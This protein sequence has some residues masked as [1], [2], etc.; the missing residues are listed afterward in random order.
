M[1]GFTLSIFTFSIKAKTPLYLPLYKGSTIRG[2]FGHALRRVCCVARKRDCVDCILRE[3]CIYSLVFETPVPEDAKMMR[4]YPSAPHPFVIDPPLDGQRLYEPGKIL[5]FRLILIGRAVDYLPYFVYSFHKLGKIGIGRDKGKF[6]LQK[7]TSNSLQG[8]GEV[9]VY[10]EEDK[11]LKSPCAPFA[12]SKIVEQ[13]PPESIRISFLTPTRIKYR[14]RLTKDVEFHVFFRN[15]L[16]RIS[17]LSYFHCGQTLN[18]HGFKELID[19]A[20]G[21][22][23]TIHTLYWNDW[24]RWSARQRTRMKLGGFIGDVTYEGDLRPFWPYIKLG[25][26]VHVGK[27]SSFGLGRYEVR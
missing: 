25:E 23:T 4:R 6:L 17:L 3:R 18:D 5:D 2:G 13:D 21:I 10:N 7:V 27:G 19:R 26:Y 1:K 24:E 9:P 15:L 16:R 11:V 12:W 22:R 20:K 8:D 14:G